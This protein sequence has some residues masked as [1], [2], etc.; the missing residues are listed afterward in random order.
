VLEDEDD[1]DARVE[2]AEVVRHG[3]EGEGR[4]GVVAPGVFDA[5]YVIF[6]GE[7]EVARKDG[8]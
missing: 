7:R 1:S 2:A 8:L 5:W 4:A 3:R 6:V